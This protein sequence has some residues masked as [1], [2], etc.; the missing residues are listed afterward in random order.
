MGFGCPYLCL[1]HFHFYILQLLL[2]PPNHF[3]PFMSPNPKTPLLFSSLVGGSLSVMLVK[4]LGMSDNSFFIF[5]FIFNGRGRERVLSVERTL[6]NDLLY[7]VLYKSISLVLY[8]GKM[9]FH[10]LICK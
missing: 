1:F 8:K 9:H 7:Y 4:F 6:E 10:I 3:P 2:S 5:I